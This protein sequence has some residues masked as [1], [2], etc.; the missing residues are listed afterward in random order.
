MYEKIS[1][2][3]TAFF[4]FEVDSSP[5]IRNKQRIIGDDLFYRVIPYILP[6]YIQKDLDM[7]LPKL[8][9]TPELQGQVL[10][11]QK[12]GLSTE[13]FESYYHKYLKSFF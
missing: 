8:S 13:F 3:A 1:S 5:A 12:I 4:D 10:F 9:F 7:H 2:R 11:A 6:E